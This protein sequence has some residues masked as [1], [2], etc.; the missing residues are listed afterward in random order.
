MS[1]NFRQAL[2]ALFSDPTGPTGPYYRG[3]P[4]GPVGGDWRGDAAPPTAAEVASWTR[5]ADSRPP[6]SI[7][8][9]LA[10]CNELKLEAPFR[11]T[12]LQKD[13]R[14]AIRRMEKK[15]VTWL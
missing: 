3:D 15:G 14:W 10:F 8:Q 9:L 13:L 6:A 11:A 4:T 7:E 12:R 1:L 2:S 5:A